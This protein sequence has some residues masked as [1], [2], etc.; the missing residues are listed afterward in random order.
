MH[1]S[2]CRNWKKS[3]LY[4]EHYWKSLCSSQA[5][6]PALQTVFIFA[7]EDTYKIVLRYSFLKS[8]HNLLSL[9]LQW[10]ETREHNDAIRLHL[11]PTFWGMLTQCYW[12]LRNGSFE[13]SL[14][15]NFRQLTVFPIVNC[16]WFELCHKGGRVSI[17]IMCWNACSQSRKN[18]N[19][20]GYLLYIMFY[21]FLG[22]RRT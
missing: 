9:H 12:L 16:C 15:G 5:F 1:N 6:E 4:R 18:E 2:N 14:L 20:M 10:K 7:T 8:L 17:I 19:Y 3:I 22:G 13:S 11:V 21:K